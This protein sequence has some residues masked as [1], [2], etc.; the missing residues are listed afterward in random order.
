M[1]QLTFH[2]FTH[3][4]SATLLKVNLNSCTNEN[5]ENHCIYNKSGSTATMHGNND[6]HMWDVLTIQNLDYWWKML[7]ETLKRYTD[8]VS[9]FF[10]SPELLGKLPRKILLLGCRDCSDSA[11][12]I[13][14]QESIT[15]QL[16]FI[17]FLIK[18]IILKPNSL[19][20]SFDGYASVYFFW[21]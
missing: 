19:S 6:W 13:V 2:I 17:T 5:K 3:R 10:N 16:L 7:K 8:S 12:D 15:F 18:T 21:N 14:L 20:L 1:V 9:C 4:R 11:V